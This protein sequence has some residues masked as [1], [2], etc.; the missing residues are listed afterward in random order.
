MNLAAGFAQRGRTLVV[1][2]D[3][4]GSASRWAG[5]APESREFPA[6]VIK[7]SGNISREIKR[8]QPDYQYLLVDCPPTLETDTAYAAMEVAHT[9]LVPVLPS[10][11]DL[12]ASLSMAK[13]VETAK[14]ANRSLKACLVLNQ[15]EARSAMSRSMHQALAEFDLPVL[16]N[17]M[18]RRAAYRNAAL[19]GTSVYGYGSRG[20]PAAEEIEAMI[21]EVLAL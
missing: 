8:F 3:P 16:Q 13:A 19:E 18:Q 10:P 20:K 14:Q 15:L 4:Q 9:V 2:A 11:V 6:S 1:D 7:L 17:G 12:W 5:L 21:K